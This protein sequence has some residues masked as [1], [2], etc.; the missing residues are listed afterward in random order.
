M[1]CRKLN[2]VTEAHGALREGGVGVL[3]EE[4]DVT[5]RSSLVVRALSGR[6]GGQA[7]MERA[8][9]FYHPMDGTLCWELQ[10]S[11]SSQYGTSDLV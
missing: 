11:G 9:D 10:G 4:A 3:M 1:D 2:K 6:N 5:S 7:L 8:L